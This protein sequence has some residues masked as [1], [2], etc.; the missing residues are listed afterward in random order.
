VLLRGAEYWT[1]SEILDTRE[2]Q[3]GAWIKLGFLLQDP[4]NCVRYGLGHTF[5]ED[6]YTCNENAAKG[7]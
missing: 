1:A 7:A 5:V 4:E 2:G 3:I 6:I